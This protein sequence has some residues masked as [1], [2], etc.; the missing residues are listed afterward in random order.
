VVRK[1]GGRVDG[2]EEAFL[3]SSVDSLLRDLGI[4]SLLQ[5]VQYRRRLSIDFLGTCIELSEG[6]SSLKSSQVKS[7]LK[8]LRRLCTELPKKAYSIPSTL[9]PLFLTTCCQQSIM[10]VIYR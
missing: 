5:I 2:I 10:A 9:P 1:S 3:G 7:I 4:Y 8:S 6:D